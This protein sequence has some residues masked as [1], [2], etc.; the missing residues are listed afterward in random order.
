MTRASLK[1]GAASVMAAVTMACSREVRLV[2]GEVTWAR[3]IAAKAR[4]RIVSASFIGGGMINAA[5]LSNHQN[6]VAF[7]VCVLLMPIGGGADW[8]HARARAL[9][10]LTV[11]NALAKA[12][13][14]VEA[15]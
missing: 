2:L 9:P 3:E 14:E 1:R 12:N 4:K 6:Q 7:S 10:K 8:M 13:L 11:A 5:E 15:E